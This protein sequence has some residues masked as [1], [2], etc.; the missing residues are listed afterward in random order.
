MVP[1]KRKPLPPA[2]RP[3]PVPFN[4]TCILAQLMRLFNGKIRLEPNIKISSRF[5]GKTAAKGTLMQRVFGCNRVRLQMIEGEDL[6]MN[7]VSSTF[8]RLNGTAVLTLLVF[9]C[10]GAPQPRDN[11][12]VRRLKVS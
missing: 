3:L 10:L 7:H 12:T 9:A 8:Q 6:K 11:R 2:V 4:P 5:V 1:S